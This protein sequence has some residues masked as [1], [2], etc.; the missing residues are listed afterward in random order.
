MD[1]FMS[2]ALAEA[3]RAAALGEVP[4]GAVLVREG[5]VV[6]S[7]HNERQ[8]RRSPSAHAEFLCIERACASLGT[9]IL[10]GCT[11]YVTLEPCP[12]CAGLILAARVE[13]VV[14]AAPDPAAGCFGSV[15]D[16]S[17]A[18]LGFS[19]KIERSPSEPCSRLLT[20]FFREMR[21]RNSR[22]KC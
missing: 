22:L 19:P 5:S 18:P 3:E 1:D 6:A 2:L 11:L 13:K 16:F 10:S 9:R 4:V 20:E 17:K 12:M 15:L 8:T 14:F 7:A 21:E